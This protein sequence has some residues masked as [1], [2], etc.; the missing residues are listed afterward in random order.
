MDTM[1]RIRDEFAL[2]LMNKDYTK[3][4]RE[5]AMLKLAGST[6]IEIMGAKFNAMEPVLFGSLNDDY[7]KREEAWYNS[8]SLNVNDIPDGPPAIWKSVADPDGF[9]NSNYGWCIYSADNGNQY[10]NVVRELLANP[11]SRRAV[12][13]YNRPSMWTDYNKNGR[14]D[15]MCTNDVQYMIRDGYLNAIV[16][17]RSNDCILGYKNDFAWQKHVLNKLANE[18]NAPIG[19]IHWNAGSFH[20]YSRHYFL[21]DHYSKTGEISITKEQYSINYPNSQYK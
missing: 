2:K 11:E 9:I 7:I 5:Q 21:V 20:V 12:M 3:V 19:K 8:M 13:I 6:T 14:S 10:N 16:N 18:L 1:K 15:F 17:M 4:N